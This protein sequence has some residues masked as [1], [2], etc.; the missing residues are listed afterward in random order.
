MNAVIKTNY[1]NQNCGISEKI[2]AHE[3]KELHKAFSVFVHDGNGNMLIQKRAKDKYHSGGLW[4]NACC[5]H[6]LTED[7]ISEAQQRMI[8]ELG[9]SCDIEY[10]DEFIYYTEFENG[11]SEFELDYVFVGQCNKNLDISYN[12]SEVEEIKWIGIDA[13]I[14]DVHTNP[15]KY[16][17]WFITALYIVI[18]HLK[19]G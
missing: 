2:K 11:I 4:T 8:E 16:T 9:F 7:V 5:S 17:K 13:L 1:L 14:A 15:T 12:N 18:R 10:V 6:P 3:N 19:N